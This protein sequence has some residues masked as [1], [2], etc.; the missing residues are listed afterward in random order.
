MP[1]RTR[2]GGD[3]TGSPPRE[4]SFE[5]ERNLRR[6][7][8]AERG[9]D[10]PVE[11]APVEDAAAPINEVLDAAPADD[12]ATELI[13]AADVGHASSLGDSDHDPN[14][15]EID[16]PAVEEEGGAD[17]AAHDEAMADG[18]SAQEEDAANTRYR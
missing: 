17:E 15:T 2:Y 8:R 3:D 11:D 1:R 6:L 12:S 10:V 13:D 9:E 16:P 18:R 4:L 14:A 7:A 5:E